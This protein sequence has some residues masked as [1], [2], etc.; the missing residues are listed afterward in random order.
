M[1]GNESRLALV[2]LLQGGPQTVS[3][4]VEQTGLSQPLVSQHLRTLREGGL[5]SG[6]RDGREV[7][8]HLAD[9][10]VAHVVSD[11]LIHVSESVAPDGTAANLADP[12]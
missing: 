1:L 9:H 7:T 8:Y 4:L 5:I 12:S 11:A 3:W 10:H 6:T 2:M